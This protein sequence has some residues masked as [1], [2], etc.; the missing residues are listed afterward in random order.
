MNIYIFEYVE[1]LTSNYHPQGGIVVIAENLE[2][3]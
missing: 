2:R 3:V 1:K